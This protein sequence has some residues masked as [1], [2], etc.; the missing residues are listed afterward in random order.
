M[1]VRPIRL[2]GDPIL[3]KPAIEVVEFDA[4]LRQLVG[5]LTDTMLDAPGA[6]AP[7]EALAKSTPV[8]SVSPIYASFDANEEV[9]T[10]NQGGSMDL[11][12][13]MTIWAG[14]RA[15]V[16]IAPVGSG[17]VVNV[18]ENG[19]SIFSTKVTIDPG[20]KTSLGAAVQPVLSDTTF[21]NDS[22]MTFDIDQVGST[23][24]GQGLIVTLLGTML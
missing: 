19:T 5:D 13:P 2:F 7:A 3:R 20:T 4:E 17:I 15:S 1:T 14:V 23:T 11:G 22:E 12:A 16:L 8:V 10:R 21:A 9:I 6:G 24:A 18:K